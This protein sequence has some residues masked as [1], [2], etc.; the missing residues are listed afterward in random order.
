M[1][2]LDTVS[3]KNDLLWIA[4]LLGCP[5]W[6]LPIIFS[7]MRDINRGLE[8]RGREASIFLS[9]N[10]HPDHLWQILCF[11]VTT[12]SSC[13][14]SLEFSSLAF[15]N[16]FFPLQSLQPSWLWWFFTNAGLWMPLHPMFILISL[17]TS[18][19]FLRTTFTKVSLFESPT[20]E[21]CA[22]LGKPTDTVSNY[23]SLLFFSFC[24]KKGQEFINVLI[25]PLFMGA[26]IMEVFFQFD[27]VEKGKEKGIGLILRSS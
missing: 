21:F 27:W 18:L 10:S 16:A 5:C 3:H 19:I 24:M 1:I 12:P 13:G 6:L 17:P 25:T 26:C 4:S 8:S 9:S 2:I 14:L 20:C 11:P 23:Q 22:L 7:L 15:I